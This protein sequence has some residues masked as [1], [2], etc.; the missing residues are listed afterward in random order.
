MSSIFVDFTFDFK[1]ISTAQAFSF[2]FALLKRK[3]GKEA[4]LKNKYFAFMLAP[5]AQRLFGH[6]DFLFEK[7]FTRAFVA[8]LSFVAGIAFAAAFSFSIAGAFAS[9][10]SAANFL[11]H[12]CRAGSALFA[13]RVYIFAARF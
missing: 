5:R 1:S 11:I 12:I 8:V 2:A 10:S 7:I 13:E 9:S 4:H 6:R 3:S